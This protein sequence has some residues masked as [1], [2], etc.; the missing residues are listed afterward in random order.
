MNQKVSSILI[1][2]SY[3]QARELGALGGKLL[4]AGKAGYLLIFSS[5]L[6]QRAIQEALELKG[7]RLEH[8]HF[9]KSGL[10]VWSTNR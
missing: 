9:S 5:P 4:G 2:E 6:Y 10:E 7:C 1:E 3:N 8:V